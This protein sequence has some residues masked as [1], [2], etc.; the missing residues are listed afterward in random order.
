MTVSRRQF[1]ALLGTSSAVGLA[2]VAGVGCS[3]ESEDPD[4]F[5]EIRFGLERC[6]HCGMVID[7]P[8][9]ASASR[10]VGAPSRHFDDIGCLVDDLSERAAPA[11]TRAFVHDFDHEEWLHA[12]DATFVMSPEIRSPMASGIAAMTTATRAHEVASEVNGEVLTWTALR[13]RA[14]TTHGAGHGS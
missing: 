2:L 5:P 9:F 11:S 14:G 3:N 1:L 10:D 4:A 8:R 7:D 13:P 12:A 6:E